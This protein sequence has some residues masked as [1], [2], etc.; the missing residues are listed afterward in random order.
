M[1]K[2]VILAVLLM[3]SLMMTVLLAGAASAARWRLNLGVGY[4]TYSPSLGK[5]NQLIQDCNSWA[6]NTFGLTDF[7]MEEMKLTGPIYSLNSRTEIGPRWEVGLD[8][9]YWQAKEISLDKDLTIPLGAGEKTIW[10]YG[11]FSGRVAFADFIVYRKFSGAKLAPFVGVGLGYYGVDVWGDYSAWEYTY[12][13]P[14]SWEYRDVY[15][16]F[17]VSGSETGYVLAAGAV[18]TPLEHLRL[19]LE[20]R[21]HIVPELTGEFEV[22]NEGFD[23]LPMETEPFELD[24]SGPTIGVNLMLRF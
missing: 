5:I 12:V 14:W 7:G 21:Y 15:E 23:S 22:Y 4:G 6:E 1:R 11:D 18:W 13:P 19:A 17:S 3:L 10:L 9:N 24:F 2:G 20:V 16:S 8:L